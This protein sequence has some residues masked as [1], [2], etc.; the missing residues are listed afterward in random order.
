VT[1]RLTR[2]A[3][4]L[5]L[6]PHAV[7]RHFGLEMR[8]AGDELRGRLC[9]SCGKR[10]R[11]SV[12]LNVNSGRWSC[13]AHGCCG[14]LFSF[15][16]GLAG[17][18]VRRDFGRVLEVAAE[19]AGV[20]PTTDPEEAIRFRRRQIEREAAERI[21]Q[22]A[23]RARREA[24]ARTRASVEWT[25]LTRHLQSAPGRQYVRSRGLDPQELLK[26]SV[27]RFYPSGDVAT[28]LWGFDDGE[29]VNVVRRRI[30]DEDPKVLGLKDCPTAGTM[31]AR[32][33]DISDKAITI[34]VEGVA[35]S[36]TAMTAWPDATV[37][38]AHGA[39]NL[40]KVAEAARTRLARATGRIVIVPHRD[41]AGAQATAAVRSRLVD[42]GVATARIA[43]LELAYKD[44]N[45]AWLAGWRP[46]R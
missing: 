11:E 20:E 14:D 24:D 32:V 36:W 7:L 40:P 26:C 10:A 1:R 34:I 12:A 46:P 6:T 31:G 13:F 2:D 27:I 3:V 37:L 22:A 38:G 39:G 42:G 29:L 44:L 5:A 25:G 8:P 28:P 4:A 41:H 33:R 21:E 17:L 16:A 23:R 43:V 18:D 15:V 19:I 30:C 45:D 35:D 9:P